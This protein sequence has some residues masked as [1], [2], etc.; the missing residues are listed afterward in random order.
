MSRNMRDLRRFARAYIRP[1]AGM[2]GVVQAMHIVAAG[3]ILL[4]PLAV[5]YAI[6]VAV[7]AGDLYLLGLTAAAVVGIFTA[8]FA[9]AA[10]KEY[11]GHEVAQG[12]TSRLR[13]DLYAHFQKLSMSFH[14]RS[15]AGGLLSRIVDDINVVQE[16][17]HHGPEAL[18]LGA[19][20]ISGATG[21]MFFLNWK[22]ALA[23][24]AFVPLLVVFVFRVAGRMWQQFREVRK[25]K[26]ALADVLE[27]NLSGIQVIKAF[28]TEDRELAT[29]ADENTNHYHSRMSVIRYMCRLFPG[30]MLINNMG[31]AVV[32]FYGGYLAIEGG[33]GFGD[34]MAFIMLLGYFLHPIMRLVM[35]MEHAGR[36]FAS[37]ERF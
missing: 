9:A 30:A 13:N 26:E 18:V 15:K 28:G 2:F 37:L 16:V 6:N 34:L 5:R 20:M 4:P 31:L 22:L 32:V 25:R 17:I 11:F 10:F 36:F 8:F 35:M 1:R 29:I 27:E 19:V 24:L 14:D 7:P 33:I 21:L 23:V 3:L 12:I